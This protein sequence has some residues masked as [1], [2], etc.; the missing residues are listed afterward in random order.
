MKNL[1][2]SLLLLL[3]TTLAHAQALK[4]DQKKGNKSNSSR[5]TDII[6]KSDGSFRLVLADEKFMP[7]EKNILLVVNGKVLT[8]QDID[9]DKIESVKRL[10][11]KEAT[12]SYGPQGEHGA[13]VIAMKG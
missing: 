12:A 13:L 8:N 2:L 5:I 9:P 6:K 1:C 10:N 11:K 7:K 4:P 3:G